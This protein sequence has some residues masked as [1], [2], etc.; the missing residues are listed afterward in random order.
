M[1]H[2]LLEEVIPYSVKALLQSFVSVKRYFTI[3]SVNQKIS[4]FKF[5]WT[6]SKSKPSQIPS[7][8]LHDGGSIHQSGNDALL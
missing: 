1:I 8:I 4:S 3:D 7:T 2:V 6:E 5:S